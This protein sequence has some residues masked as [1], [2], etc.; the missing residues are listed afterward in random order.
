[1][2]FL[3]RFFLFTLYFGAAWSTETYKFYDSL[4]NEYELCSIRAD[5]AL[6]PQSELEKKCSS[7]MKE[8]LNNQDTQKHTELQSNACEFFERA[9]QQINHRLLIIFKMTDSDQIPIAMGKVDLLADIATYI[10][11][12]T[13]QYL[14]NQFG[15]LDHGYGI[16]GSITASLRRQGIATLIS[17]KC[18]NIIVKDIYR[19]NR[20]QTKNPYV[21]FSVKR[22]NI[23]MN[24]LCE[25]KGYKKI[26]DENGRNYGTINNPIYVHEY[27][28]SNI[29]NL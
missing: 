22:D 10:P 13:K 7:F 21:F 27:I 5:R 6:D 18:L 29:D 8:E 15:D 26:T 16:G 17:T 28:L 1:M 9:S 25:K 12:A 11:E 23:P 3:S 2:I 14:L 19:D 4:N 24:M 20:A